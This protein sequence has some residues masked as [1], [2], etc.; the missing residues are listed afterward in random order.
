MNVTH[1]QLILYN[2]GVYSEPMASSIQGKLFTAL[3]LEAWVWKPD[4]DGEAMKERHTYSQT[5]KVGS[6]RLFGFCWSGTNYCNIPEAQCIH[7][8]Q[9]R[10]GVNYVS[11]D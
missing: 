2:M 6:D 3:T 11:S 10:G 1:L 5:E 7:Y 4:L 9:Y 8:I